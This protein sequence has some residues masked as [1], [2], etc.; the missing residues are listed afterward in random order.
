MP[1]LPAR[2]R[3]A[4]HRAEHH[5]RRGASASRRCEPRG[6]SQVRAVRV[7]LSLE[8]ALEYDAAAVS[9]QARGRERRG[10]FDLVLA[11][12]VAVND[13]P[14]GVDRGAGDVL[15]SNAAGLL[16]SDGT[17]RHVYELVGVLGGDASGRARSFVVVA[18]SVILW[19]GGWDGGDRFQTGL[20]GRVPR[21]PLRGL[22][23]P[24]GRRC[25]NLRRAF[26]ALSS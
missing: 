7:D 19:G 25:G 6:P 11:V 4:S 1:L 13:L 12:V 14:R 15:E 2:R 20:R 26:F 22:V 5:R 24:G 23:Q 21:W 18:P 9:G 3:I 16:L 8:E 10:R 17:V